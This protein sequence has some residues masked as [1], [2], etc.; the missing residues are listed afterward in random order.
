MH[1]RRALG[2]VAT[3]IFLVAIATLMVSPAPSLAGASATPALP[4]SAGPATS[5]VGAS[6]AI[7]PQVPQPLLTCPTPPNPYPIYG[8][9]GWITPLQTQ[10][11]PCPWVDQDSAH[12]SFFSNSPASAE[13]VRIP[14]HLP[15][16]GSGGQENAYTD[17]YLGEPVRGDTESVDGQSYAQVMFVANTSTSLHYDL[18]AHVWSIVNSSTPTT[19]GGGCPGASVNFTWNNSFFCEV[20]DVGGGFGRNIGNISAGTWVNVT[21]DGTHGGSRG[22]NV[23]LNDSTGNLA[24]YVYN[25]SNDNAGTTGLTGNW[26]FT[27]AFG[28][29]CALTCILNWSMPF[30]L[31]FGVDTCPQFPQTYAF[32][33]S[34]NQDIW[35]TIPPIEI[36]APAFFANGSYS[37]DYRFIGISSGSGACNQVAAQGTVAVC[38]NFNVYGGSGFYPLVTFNGS[39]LNFGTT[40]PWTTEAFGGVNIEYSSSGAIALQTPFFA[41]QMHNS[42]RGGFVAPATAVHVQVRL[43]DLGN[44]SSANLTYQVGSATPATVAMSLVSGTLSNGRWNATIPSGSNGYINYTVSATNR[45]GATVRTV[46]ALV[47]RGP[48]PQFALTFFSSPGTCGGVVFNGTFKVNF[49]SVTT[50]PGTYTLGDIAC[51]PYV[52]GSW[53]LTSGLSV[54]SLTQAQT[55][56]T[57]SASGSIE[58]ELTYVRPND[59][60]SIETNPSSCGSFT[61]NGTPVSNGSFLILPDALAYTLASPTGCSSDGSFSGWTFSGNFTILGSRFTPH[62]NGTLVANFVPSGSAD[63]LI[64]YTSP[65]NCGGVLFRGAGYTNGESLNV[66]PG[67]YALGDAPCAHFGFRNFSSS[68]GITTTATTIDVN[69][70]GWVRVTDYSLTEIHIAMNP[71]GCGYISVDGTNYR[72]GQTVV[73]ANN[74]THSVGN[75]ACTGYSLFGFN[76]SG[77]LRLFGNVLVANGSGTLLAVYQ[78]GLAKSFVG[79][80]TDPANCGTINFGGLTFRNSNYTFVTPGSVVALSAVPCTNYGFVGWATSGGIAIV[81]NTAYLNG[82]GGSITAN[83]HALV[84]IYIYTLPS[85]CGSVELNGVTYMNNGTAVLPEDAA[86][87]LR[88]TPCAHYTLAQWQNTTSALISGNLVFFTG[89]AIL[90]ASFAKS[91]YSV[92]I[93]TDPSN[94]GAVKIGNLQLSNGTTVGL[95]FGTYSIVPVL[96]VGDH[97][98]HWTI[99]GNLTITGTQLLVNGSGSIQGVY[100]PVPPTVTLTLPV[101]SYAGETVG[102]LATVAVPVPP[103]N[104]TY[105]WT[106]GDGTTAET[107]ANATSHVYSSSGTYTV[108][109]KVIDPYHRVAQENATISI[110]P[111]S[112]LTST[113]IP[114]W[115]LYVASAFFSV[116]IGVLLI[117]WALR[118][119]A[120]PSEPDTAS[121]LMGG[122]SPPSLEGAPSDALPP[123][124]TPPPTGPE[125]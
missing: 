72:Q 42:S 90:T 81:G 53:N 67:S 80:V 20:D 4:P 115:S 91:S 50:L 46:N 12:V 62:G 14:I 101:S 69:A 57:V 124:E 35:T 15:S 109:V 54:A 99:D 16:Q 3:G 40:Y 111:S 52:F 93:T 7:G 22:L 37:G 26:N 98:D 63:S 107:P 27:P 102:V 75:I 96:C 119:R 36:G 112:G 86:Y 70:G 13:N 68:T 31:G 24:A 88:A 34:F 94:C 8:V 85:G 77:G 11:S 100:R 84:A 73:V 23:W 19:W 9:G 89:P 78:R 10:Q 116:L 106:F 45:A 95:I 61:L 64:F 113:G 38:P 118:R 71:A 66:L 114:I 25:S 1:D 56:L 123:L 43:Q 41:D 65:T 6:P 39:L 82:T 105:D 117:G 76:T 48:L 29:S 122:P 104:Y 60:I 92:A 74:S 33:D 21:F 5:T 59:T 125:P 2:A 55:N 18:F 79:F 110:V 17:F 51:Y 47:I 97:L 103:F 28:S 49:T 32:C 120:P 44:V 87:S 121:G 30:G 58:Q 83:F 108:S